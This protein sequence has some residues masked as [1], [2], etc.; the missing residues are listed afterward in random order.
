MSSD[1]YIARLVLGEQQGLCNIFSAPRS[2]CLKFHGLL[3]LVGV[4]EDPSALMM[5]GRRL[6]FLV[7]SVAVTGFLEE[8]FKFLPFFLVIVRFR[9]F[10][11]PTDG[12]IYAG[13]IALGFA[14]F[15]NIIQC[16]VL[17]GFERL[18][19]AFASPLTQAMF[20][21]IWGYAVGKARIAG[22]ALAWPAVRGLV[23]AALCHG[24]FNFLTTSAALHVLSAALILVIWVWVII[25]LERAEKRSAQA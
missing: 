10:D 23:L 12:L 5:S 21:S 1:F 17:E 25:K 22:R 3:P 7:Y 11:E 18:G 19:R 14:S 4:A 13:A 9:E 16:A 20:S 24:V 6:P 2:I 15:E 8:T